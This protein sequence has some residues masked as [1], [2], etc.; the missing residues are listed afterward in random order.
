LTD[1]DFWLIEDP[2]DEGFS[3]IQFLRPFTR[4]HQIQ[5]YGPSQSRL[6]F[7]KSDED[8]NVAEVFA[9]DHHINIAPGRVAPLGD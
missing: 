4:C 3:V 9:N 5:I 7:L 1:Y 8:L 6:G 2:D